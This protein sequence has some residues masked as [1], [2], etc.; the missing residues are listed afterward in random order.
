[1][2]GFTL[3]MTQFL[4]DMTFAI[5][6]FMGHGSSGAFIH[7]ILDV[8]CMVFASEETRTPK[9]WTQC[10][11]IGCQKREQTSRFELV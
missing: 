4:T 6:T 7:D 2:V 5:D 1:M 10:L 11:D 8:K 3:M 9:T